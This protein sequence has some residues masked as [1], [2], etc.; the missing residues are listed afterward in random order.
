MNRTVKNTAIYFAGTIISAVVGFLNTMLL[1]RVLDAKVYAMYG[2][3]ATFVTA[4]TTFIAFGYDSAYSRFYYKHSFTPKRF[5][6]KT[7]RTPVIVFGVFALVLIEP[8]QFLLAYVFGE[9][10]GLTTV[11]LLL[12]YILFAFL[13][14][15]TQL[16]ARME[17]R[18]LNYVGSN[19]VGKFG[20]VALVVV[21]FWTIHNV[22]FDWVV[23][24]F[25]ISSVLA[26][27]MNVLVFARMRNERNVSGEAVT[28]RDLFS[29]GFPYMLNNVMILIVPLVE[30]LIIRDVAGWQVLGIYTAAA[31]FQTVVL[32]VTNTIINIWNPLV[33]KHCDNE[34]YF[35]PVLHLFGQAAT[36][37]LVIG[38]AFCIL[39]RRWL[40]LVLDQSYRTDVSIIAPAILFGAC[41]N[42]LNIIYSVGI[43]IKKK[44]G[45]FIVSPLLQL[46]ISVG[47]C[48]LLVPTM[49]LTGVAIATLASLVISKTYR[50]LVGMHFYNTGVSEWK[51]VVLCT[52]GVAASVFA[53][54]YTSLISDVLVFVVVI[55][56]TIAVVNKDLMMLVRSMKGIMR[57]K[58]LSKKKEKH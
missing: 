16:T 45:Y 42:I 9:R 12:V 58:D 18:A 53:L 27:L 55:A 50:I 46:G 34:T 35:K 32:L 54:F 13:H 24:S 25:L 47:L 44:T 41:F 52:L 39:L 43:N 11:V 56:A 3:L 21:V 26:T 29:Y 1:T 22:K 40:V 28:E 19:F 4:A 7:L 36:V 23:L 14:R 15:F 2:L 38:L 48:Y 49:G 8:N 10:L 33:F 5:I 51:T 6:W 20:Y 30:K 57:G 37:I 17:E 31:V